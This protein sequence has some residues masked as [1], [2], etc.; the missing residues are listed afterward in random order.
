MV[1]KKKQAQQAQL[2]KNA[3][4]EE[5]AKAPS[6]KE[7]PPKVKE[8]PKER[9]KKTAEAKNARQEPP[10]KPADTKRA[11]TTKGAE[12]ANKEE[13]PKTK[14]KGEDPLPRE[15]RGLS[16]AQQRAVHELVAKKQVMQESD[17]STGEE[18]DDTASASSDD[19]SS[20]V[21]AETQLRIKLQQQDE[22]LEKLRSAQGQKGN[23]VDY[24][25]G[26]VLEQQ[27][28]HLGT[29][30]LKLSD[31]MASKWESWIRSM[32]H[33]VAQITKDRVNH[34]LAHD[35]IGPLVRY[36]SGIDS[37]GKAPVLSTEL[38]KPLADLVRQLMAEMVAIVVRRLPQRAETPDGHSSCVGDLRKPGWV[39]RRHWARMVVP[40]TFVT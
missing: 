38:P 21:S 16:P 14:P 24:A 30:G 32:P 25:K 5:T 34:L 18:D 10:K 22:E 8:D 26:T 4:K 29:N 7:A 35:T 6:K 17:S 28:L 13:P 20:T 15:L 19:T 11:R 40:R 9:S 3:K 2:P 27:A 36:L 1:A 12:K 39:R 37:H 31:A 33:G 23:S